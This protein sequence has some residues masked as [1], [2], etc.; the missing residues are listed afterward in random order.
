[1]KHLLACLVFLPGTVLANSPTSPN[2]GVPQPTAELKVMTERLHLSESQQNEIAP[3]LVSESDKRKSIQDDTTLS[4][5]QKHD[6]TGEIHRAALQQIKAF[7]TPEQ[8]ALIEQGQQHPQTGLT[9]P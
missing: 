6:Q 9:H 3:I 5:Q 2:G 4:D 8:L 1:M 7:F